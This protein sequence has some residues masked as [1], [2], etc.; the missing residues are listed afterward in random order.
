MRSVNGVRL[1]AGAGTGIE[2][3]TDAEARLFNGASSLA[4]SLKEVNVGWCEDV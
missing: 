1:G 3:V 2:D 4:I